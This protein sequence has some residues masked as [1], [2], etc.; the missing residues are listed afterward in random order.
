MIELPEALTIASQMARA[1]AGS[2]VSK[3]VANHS[4]HKWAWFHG[5]PAGYNALLTGR[6]VEGAAAFGSFV[7]LSF[8][9]ATLL[10]AEG[11]NMRIYDAGTKLPPKHQLLLEFTDGAERF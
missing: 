2:T 6:S 1:L 4:P 10:L 9:G 8:A 11:V 3:V 5:D 7:E